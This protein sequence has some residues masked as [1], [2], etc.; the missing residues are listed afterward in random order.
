MSG[1]V[2]LMERIEIDPT[3]EPG[4]YDCSPHFG[5]Y[6]EAQEVVAYRLYSQSTGATA[7]VDADTFAEMVAAG[8]IVEC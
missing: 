6:G 5:G 1:S 2:R 7:R 4:E 3:L 8:K